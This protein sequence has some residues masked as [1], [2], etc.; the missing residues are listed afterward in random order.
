MSAST[1]THIGAAF[2]SLILM[3]GGAQ[4]QVL[5]KAAFE[6]RVF[7][8]DNSTVPYT[9]TIVYAPEKKGSSEGNRRIASISLTI[10]GKAISIPASS[11]T[12]LA[13]A[14]RPQSLYTD[15]VDMNNARFQI[16]GG[17]G[18]NSYTAEFL[19]TRERLIER[20]I[21]Y[22][23]GSKPKITKYNAKSK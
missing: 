6:G 22:G 2:F 17:D 12:D 9:L 21:Q 8:A 11:Y 19:V 15:G 16:E 13:D 1:L 5:D 10:D 14:H 4:A 23:E 7:T 20:E 18:E 3:A